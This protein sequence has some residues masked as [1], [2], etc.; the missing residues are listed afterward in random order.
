MHTY[1]LTVIPK[2]SISELISLIILQ[3]PSALELGSL[4]RAINFSQR[5][6]TTVLF[7]YN[8]ICPLGVIKC[9]QPSSANKKRLRPQCE[10]CLAQLDTSAFSR[11]M[12]FWLSPYA[13]VW[14][15]ALR[16]PDPQALGRLPH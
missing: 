10:S 16:C 6:Q 2:N 7:I 9:L 11:R 5:F 13:S 8:A 14:L 15:S 4:M 3:K 12:L 1:S